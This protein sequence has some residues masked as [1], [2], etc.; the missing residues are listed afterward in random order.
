MRCAIKLYR[1]QTEQSRWF[2]HEHPNYA[3]AWKQ[4]EIISLM[5]DLQ[6]QRAVAHMCM[7][8]MQSSDELGIG[9]VKKPTGILSNSM[10]LNNKLENKCMGGNR[11]AQLVGG[12]AQAC[13]SYPDKLGR[14]ILSGIK[15]E[16]ANSGVIKIDG[17]DLM[18]VSQENH[19]PEQ[20]HVEEI[21][22]DMTGQTLNT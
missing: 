18:V 3:G 6:I 2:R 11:H 22:G 21:L 13:Q 16:L 12:K 1:L 8:R 4:P 20:K 14:A 15:L 5:D 9:K 10:C 7:Y 17:K 19:D